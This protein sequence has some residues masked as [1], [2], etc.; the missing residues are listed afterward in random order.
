MIKFM[1]KFNNVIQLLAIN[2]NF[3]GD[4]S[5]RVDTES[6]HSLR[7]EKIKMKGL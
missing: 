1:I 3:I 4:D 7:L 5:I 6:L 2:I